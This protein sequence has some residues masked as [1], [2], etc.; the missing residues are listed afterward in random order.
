MSHLA[1]HEIYDRFVNLVST[2]FQHSNAVVHLYPNNFK[3]KQTK[4]T[5][6]CVQV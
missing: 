5:S 2:Q 1:L 6:S 3:A 4:Q